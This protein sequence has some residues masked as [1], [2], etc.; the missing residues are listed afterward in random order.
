MRVGECTEPCGPVKDIIQPARGMDFETNPMS[1]PVSADRG[2]FAADCARFA[3]HAVTLKDDLVLG[4]RIFNLIGPFPRVL[5]I[6]LE[7][8]CAWESSPP[9][10]SNLC[11]TVL[12]F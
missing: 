6:G 10:L 9:H 11:Y 5:K 3:L 8:R 7:S 4:I 1:E 2:C 12:A